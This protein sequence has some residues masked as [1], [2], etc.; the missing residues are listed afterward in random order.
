M[1]GASSMQAQGPPAQGAAP[2][3]PA[4]LAGADGGFSVARCPGACDG[5]PLGWRGGDGARGWVQR[6]GVLSPVHRWVLGAR[7][8]E[9]QDCGG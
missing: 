2:G 6:E 4:L 3:A 1:G 8:A 5:A 7:A 9:G